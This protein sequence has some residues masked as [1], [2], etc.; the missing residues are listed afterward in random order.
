MKTITEIEKGSFLWRASKKFD[1]AA[2]KVIPDPL[3]FCLILT[4]LLFAGGVLFTD[5]TPISMAQY[6]YDGIWTQIGFAFQMSFMVVCCAVTA[7]SPQVAALLKRLSRTIS[8]PIMAVVFLMVFGYLTSF[9]NWAF[10][11]IV[12]P[13]MA[14][15]ISRQIRGL[16]FPMLIAAGFSTMVLGQCLSPTGTVFALVA[17][18]DH[19]LVDKIG[20]LPQTITT[21]NPANIILWIVLAISTILVTVY[22]LPP[23]S[24]TIEFNGENTEKN[25]N[26]AITPIAAPTTLAERMNSSRVIMWLVGAIGAIIIA[27]TIGNK[28]FFSSLSL[29]FVIFFFLVANF[30]LYNTPDKF[31]SAYRNN[32][33][34]A[35][36][37]MIQFPFYGGIS[38]MMASSGLAV[39]II[40]YFTSISTADTLPLLTYI[41]SSILNLFIPSQ[42]GQ[43]IIQGDIISEAALQLGANVNIIINAFVYGDQATNLL[44]PL[45][46]IPALAVVGMRLKDVWGYMA[47]LWLIWFVITAIGFALIPLF[48]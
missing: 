20:V 40:G 11:L 31:I 38:G 28:G 8:S 3:V 12:T 1:F 45:Y 35:T 17:G 47:Y 4:I 21:Y 43:W 27:Y 9:L 39:I 44:Q 24:E 48:L 34:L 29:N 19:F 13:I 22:S 23:K 10:G 36:D 2:D 14:M 33:S 18:D 7:R 42:G 32:L 37:I 26:E 6:W 16:H 15:A 30:F 5:N 25:T 41:S 46:V